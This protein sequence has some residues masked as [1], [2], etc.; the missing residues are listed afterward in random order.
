MIVPSKGITDKGE[1]YSADQSINAGYEVKRG[2]KLC[3]FSEIDLAR[4]GQVWQIQEVPFINS[5][6][7]SISIIKPC[8]RT[9]IVR[10]KLN[11]NMGYTWPSSSLASLQAPAIRL[12]GLEALYQYATTPEIASVIGQLIEE[13]RLAF[14]LWEVARDHSK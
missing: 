11:P 5:P 13:T 10:L 8:S 1:S 7:Q 12:S 9:E 2:N 6:Y 4:A 14:N 3:N